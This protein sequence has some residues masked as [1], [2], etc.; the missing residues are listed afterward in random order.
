MVS[1][2]QCVDRVV[3]GGI[4]EWNAFALVRPPGHH[5]GISEPS[6]FCIFNNVAVAAQYAIDKYGLRR[7]LILDWDVHH[8]NGTQ[9]IFWED[10][11]V[12]YISLHRHDEG[13][14]YPMG[15]PKDYADV[16]EG[17]GRGFSVNIPWNGGKIG[18]DAYRAA[19]SKIV[20]PIA[21][22]FCPELV[23]ISA[24]F[25]AAVGDPLGE[26]YVSFEVH[27]FFTQ[28]RRIWYK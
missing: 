8:G 20:M 21:Y 2:L 22:E 13:T 7:V 17:K 11:R 9:E 18:D 27:L 6:G 5:A 26:C 19:F 15:E 16:G 1:L 4:G 3:T 23:F 12:L 14:F 10:N 28:Y 24:G 25:D